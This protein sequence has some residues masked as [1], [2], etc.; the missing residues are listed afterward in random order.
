MADCARVLGKRR[1]GWAWAEAC[2]SNADLG[3]T[4]ERRELWTDGERLLCDDE[5][6]AAVRACS[7]VKVGR[8]AAIAADNYSRPPQPHVSTRD[9]SGACSAV[10]LETRSAGSAQ[11]ALRAAAA[12]PAELHIRCEV[13]CFA[14]VSGRITA[15]S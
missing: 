9:H 1:G 12:R 7:C 4:R 2:T 6:P 5:L 13:E 10:Q 11:A 3:L 15:A 8:R 14:G